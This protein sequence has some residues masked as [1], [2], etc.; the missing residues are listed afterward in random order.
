MVL[1]L[2]LAPVGCGRIKAPV[3][4]P[5]AVAKDR[6]D[7][8]QA[9]NFAMQGDLRTALPILHRLPNAALD[10]RQNRAR[11]S[12]IARFERGVPETGLTGVDAWTA[13]V[14]GAYRTYWTQLMLGQEPREQAEK[15][16]GE[17]LLKQLGKSVDPKAPMD[18][19]T[20]EPELLSALQDRG[21]HAI[22]GVT[23]PYRECL[24][25][26]G[27]TES[28]F[29]VDLPE[30]REQVTV[31]MLSDFSSLGWVGYATGDLYYCGGWTKPDRLF[32][33][34]QAYD[35]ASEAFRVSYLAHEGQHFRDSRLFPGLEQPELEYRAKLVE[36]ALADQTLGEL[37]KDF[38]GNQSQSREQPHAYAN[39]RLMD[40]LFQA[41]APQ[42]SADSPWWSG[43]DPAVIHST[44][45][46]LLA[47]DTKTQQA[48]GSPK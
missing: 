1:A 13:G 6:A 16:L 20:L 3:A 30:G 15:K 44:A 23:T 47:K 28:R 24:L 18:L 22:L 48:G 21:F 17:T 29:E 46:D 14:V 41:L 39:R 35:T 31:M 7:F 40:A 12:V 10:D 8:D 25:W 26:R 4:L 37:L 5:R 11:E 45:R 38:Q 42:V 9:M 36:V 2:V 34:A 27:Q 33:V 43:F 19:S 32:C